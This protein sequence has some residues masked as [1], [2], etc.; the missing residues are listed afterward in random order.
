MTEGALSSDTRTTTARWASNGAVGPNHHVWSREGG[1]RES[2]DGEFESRWEPGGAGEGK[3]GR[4]LNRGKRDPGR[5]RS[6]EA[7][8]L[9]REGRKVRKMFEAVRS[10]RSGP[11]KP[12]EREGRSKRGNG[13]RGRKTESPLEEGDG[14]VVKVESKRR[15]ERLSIERGERGGRETARDGTADPIV[16][17]G[18]GAKNRLGRERSPTRRGIGKNRTNESLIEVGKGLLGGTPGLGGNSLQ[19]PGSRSS[20]AKKRGGVGGERESAVIFDPE[21]GGR[22]VERETGALKKEVDFSLRLPRV[23][24]EETALTFGHVH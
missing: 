3:R 15:K 21:K 20:L 6:N 24:R 5:K 1:G 4:K 8:L 7:F 22:G 2:E 13:E 16:E 17:S 12:L 14:G 10:P 9:P 19:G 23:S 18:E 11:L